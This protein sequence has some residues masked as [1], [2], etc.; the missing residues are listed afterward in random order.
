MQ[1]FVNLM[2]LSGDL[3]TYERTVRSAG[4]IAAGQHA[5]ASLPL[6]PDAAY[7]RNELQAM[8]AKFEIEKLNRRVE[9]QACERRG[10]RLLY[11]RFTA[12]KAQKR[13]NR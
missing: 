1:W 12:E 10:A 6:S 2:A 5:I 7:R 9:Q 3:V 13:I 11:P 4:L 8:Y